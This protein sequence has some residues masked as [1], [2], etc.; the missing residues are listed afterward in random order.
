MAKTKEK[1]STQSQQ[2]EGSGKMHSDS[3]AT[4]TPSKK[5]QQSAA[6][7][8]RSTTPQPWMEA[9][10]A[11]MQRF[12]EEM[13]RVF[14]DFT[15]R[16]LLS[17]DFSRLW[18][19]PQG[20]EFAQGLW[21]PQVEA[22][23][24]EGKFIVRADLPGLSKEDVE[25]EVKDN[26]LTIRGERRHEHHE[27]KGEGRYFSERTYGSFFRSIPLPDGVDADSANAKFNDGVLEVTFDAPKSEQ[28]RSRRLDI[29]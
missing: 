7:T 8:T 1:E 2:T 13:N 4:A 20:S 26:A 28:S 19:W 15:G 12:R 6:I 21:S 27:E 24:R 10:F 18:R 17:P 5:G 29:Q 25:V 14:E 11:F 22:F 3:S 23:E 16:S 9:P